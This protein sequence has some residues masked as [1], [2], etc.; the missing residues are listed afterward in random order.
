VTAGFRVDGNSA[1]GTGFG[2]QTYPKLSASYVLSDESFWS[3][4]FIETLKLRAAVGESGKAPGAFDAVRTWDPVA[5]ENGQSAFEPSQVG[6]PQLGPERTRET[7]AGFD[8]SALRGVLTFSFSYYSSRT[9]GALVPVTLPPSLGFGARQLENIGVLTNHGTELSVNAQLL[10]RRNLDLSAGVQYTGVKSEAGDLGGQTITVDA[11]SLSFV[12]RGLPAPSYIGDRITNPGAFADPVVERNVFLGGTFPTSIISPRA[13]LR[14]WNKV[15][16]DAL[17]EFQRGGHLLNAIGFANEGLFAWQ[18]CY[19]VQS[20]LRAFAAGNT[21]ALSDVTALDRGRCAIAS[22][23]RSAGFWVEKND[24][25]KLRSVSITA[26][27]PNRLLGSSN[28]TSITLSGRN[29]FKSTP[30][31]GT[32]PESADQ[33]VNTF[34]RRD[35][36][37]FPSPRTFLFTVHTSF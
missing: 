8:A 7:E 36:Y 25:F 22:S 23:V 9:S 26:D 30:Y 34:S 20:K 5:A 28:A 1:F 13:T 19:A 12:Q 11:N 16:L 18:P 21:S 32:D 14:V 3:P 37:I 27:L 31:T 15:S 24:F 6:N 4:R 2:L 17:G 10:S 29:L 33:G 35:Y